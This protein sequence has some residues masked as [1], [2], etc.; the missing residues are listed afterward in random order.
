M[1]DRTVPPAR[2]FRRAHRL[3][4]SLPAWLNVADS[5]LSA[6]HPQRRRIASNRIRKSLQ[7]SRLQ[8]SS[9]QPWRFGA[10]LSRPP[11]TASVEITD[12]RALCRMRRARHRQVLSASR[13]E[14]ARSCVLPVRV[15][16]LAP[17]TNQALA[18]ALVS[19]GVAEWIARNSRQGQRQKSR[20]QIRSIRD[21]AC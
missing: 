6:N 3:Y 21:V 17:T 10:L 18:K 13:R 2:N 16:A 14:A 9:D 20:P 12:K 5:E 11:R 1:L 8:R 4:A 19:R 7:A 15:W